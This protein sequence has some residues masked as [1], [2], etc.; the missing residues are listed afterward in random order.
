VSAAMA[1]GGGF[2]PP[3]LAIDAAALGD[4]RVGVR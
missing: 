1:A 2:A 4:G 3:P